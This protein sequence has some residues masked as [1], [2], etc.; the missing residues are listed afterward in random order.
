M[1]KFSSA[2]EAAIAQLSQTVLGSQSLFAPKNYGHP[3][4][5]PADLIWI[6]GR[7]AVIM[8]MTAS[9]NRFNFKRKHNLDQM[10][11]WV[12]HWE[13]GQS[14]D[15]TVRNA[16]VSFSFSD[17]DHIIVLSIVGG[18]DTGSIYEHTRMIDANPKLMVCATISDA[19]FAKLASK[20]VGVNDLI[21]FCDLLEALPNER[22]NDKDAI[23]LIDIWTTELAEFVRTNVRDKLNLQ[24]LNINWKQMRLMIF[25]IIKQ[26]KLKDANDVIADLSLYDALW[27]NVAEGYSMTFQNGGRENGGAGRR[28]FEFSDP[29]HLMFVHSDGD[30]A[31]PPHVIEEIAE[32][33]ISLIRF[34]I[35]DMGYMYAI[36]I[37]QIEKPKRYIAK[38]IAHRCRVVKTIERG[39][40]IKP[41]PRSTRR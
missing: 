3:E 22:I 1:S 11:K 8:Y 12:R 28:M 41:S 6:S 40:H 36:T 16:D 2:Q 23:G 17:I 18:K 26:H 5:E 37:G 30:A 24:N 35:A 27:F 25:E 10:D 31:V 14:L 9:R 33:D 15:G 39:D 29:Y 7:C 21:D 38:L 32:R 34:D 13:I 19:V 20:I 4:N